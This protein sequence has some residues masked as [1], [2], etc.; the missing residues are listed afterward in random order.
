MCFRWDVARYSALGNK[1]TGLL[2]RIIG[3]N[4]FCVL[5]CGWR[6]MML[7]CSGDELYSNHKNK[8]PF[9][10]YYSY[11][12]SVYYHC[13]YLFINSSSHFC[14]SIKTFNYLFLFSTTLILLHQTTTARFTYSLRLT[15]ENLSSSSV[16]WKH[17]KKSE[18]C[19][20]ISVVSRRRRQP[21][22]ALSEQ[23]LCYT[24]WCPPNWSFSY[25]LNTTALCPFDFFNK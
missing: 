17:Q 2:S 11:S 24:F 18:A 15:F 9:S 5:S 25:L 3:S 22:T 6:W 14:C 13:Y 19:I 20:C 10:L 4:Q 12:S 21:Q 23:G 7:D 1:L 16:M 8:P